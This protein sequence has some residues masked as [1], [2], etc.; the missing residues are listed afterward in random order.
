MVSNMTKTFAKFVF[1]TVELLHQYLAVTFVPGRHETSL[2]KDKEGDVKMSVSIGLQ[3]N[4]FQL[5]VQLIRNEYNTF[6]S[7]SKDGHDYH[8]QNHVGGANLAELTYF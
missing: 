4:I 5:R 3:R 1:V 7:G 8:T 2:V 6:N